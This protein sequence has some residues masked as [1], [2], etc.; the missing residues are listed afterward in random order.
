LILNSGTGAKGIAMLV[1]MAKPIVL[2]PLSRQTLRRFL[3]RANSDDLKMLGDLA[4]SGRLRPVIDR[5]Y[6][7]TDTVEA[8]VYIESGHAR[9][10]VVITI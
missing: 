3:S 4:D 1:R 10:K 7:L 8:L 9:G 6:P 2:S 5:T